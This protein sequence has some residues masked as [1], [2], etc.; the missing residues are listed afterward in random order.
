MAIDFGPSKYT[1]VSDEIADR[2]ANS[3]LPISSKVLFALQAGMNNWGHAYFHGDE[4]AQVVYGRNRSITRGMRNTVYEKIKQFR[5]A[6]W[7]APESTNDCIVLDADLFQRGAGRGSVTDHCFEPSHRNCV[8]Y[9]WSS[10]RG[11]LTDATDTQTPADD[12]ETPVADMRSP[13]ACMQTPVDPFADQQERFLEGIEGL[14][15]LEGQELEPSETPMETSEPETW[16]SS[17]FAYGD[18]DPLAD[19]RRAN[20]RFGAAREHKAKVSARSDDY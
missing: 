7:I 12:R 13:V 14:E 2:I 16:Q 17:A 4:L 15:A 18:D 5:D 20:E 1:A 6:G 9:R 3:R 19:A 10:T 8:R 11:W